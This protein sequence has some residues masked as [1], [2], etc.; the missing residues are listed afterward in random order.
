MLICAVVHQNTY[1]LPIFGLY[2]CFSVPDR[3]QDVSSFEF[4]VFVLI[5]GNKTIPSVI[6]GDSR[7]LTGGVPSWWSRRRLCRSC[8]FV[9]TV[10]PF[11]SAF[12]FTF[13]A[14]VVGCPALAC[15]LEPAIFGHVA[16]TSAYEA[17][18]L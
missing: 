14:L 12:A 13:L 6:L 2:E 10:L 1:N 4:I 5:H 9:Y 15:V 3:C 17:T 11:A 18:R 7:D 16:N 8:D